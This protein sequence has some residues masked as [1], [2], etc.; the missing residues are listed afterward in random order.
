MR[1]NVIQLIKN[2]QDLLLEQ[3]NFENEIENLKLFKEKFINSTHILIPNIYSNFSNISNKIIIMDYLDGKLMSN[4]SKNKIL[5]YFSIIRSFIFE[6]ILFNNVVHGDLH[7]GNIILLKDNRIGIIDFGLVIKNTKVFTKYVFNLLIGIKNSNKD[8]IINSLLK[9]ILKDNKDFN[10]VKE[11][12]INN[13]VIYQAFDRIGSKEILDVIKIIKNL[14]IEIDSLTCRNI[15]SI[16]S[17]LSLIEK[18]AENKS[19]KLIF[20]DYLEGSDLAL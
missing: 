18:I 13:D 10:K 9:I 1:M 16:I 14:N 15:L 6:S 8:L 12:L 2:N 3:C 17:C 5:P 11:N 4:I 7:L 19:L 20:K